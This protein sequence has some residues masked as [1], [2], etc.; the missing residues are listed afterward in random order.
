MFYVIKKG[1]KYFSSGGAYV[2]SSGLCNGVRWVSD[3]NQA[4]A[5]SSIEDAQ[6]VADHNGGTCQLF[7]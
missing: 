5:T 7:A 1:N 2:N 3:V 4:W 6:A